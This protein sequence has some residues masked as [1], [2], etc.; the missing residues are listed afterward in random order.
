MKFLKFLVVL[1][2]IFTT[3]VFCY[4]YLNETEV[5]STIRS[6]YDRT[7]SE[8]I[9]NEY[10][11]EIEESFVHLTD[12]FIADNYDELLDIYYTIMSSGMTEF[13]FFCGKNYDNCIED[14]V[15]LNDDVELLS[16]MNNFV[17]VY[18]SFRSIKTTYTTNGKIMLSINR[19]Y[20][21][22]DIDKINSKL[23][24]L[25]NKIINKNKSDYDNILSI[26]DYIINNSKYDIES[27]STNN[28]SDSSTAIGIFFN[29]LATCNGYTD[30]ASLLMDRLNIKN[31]RIT[32]ENHIWNLVYLNGEWLHL[33]LTWDD[34]VS[35]DNRNYLEHTYFLINTKKLD[36]KH[37]YN[38]EIFKFLEK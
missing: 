3:S 36:D 25:E 27:E 38:K 30:A 33:D 37:E 1:L 35:T 6:Y 19:T 23:D 24:E 22:A 31:I 8:L 21:N 28:F 29:N 13:T 15:N 17:H 2:T 9:N 16:E 5:I 18:N 4:G 7:P 10:Q 12:D 11:K 32:G 20:S 26:H 14:V 34:P